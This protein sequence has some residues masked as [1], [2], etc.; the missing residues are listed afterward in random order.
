MVKE[1][2]VQ[3]PACRRRFSVIGKRKTSPC[4]TRVKELPLNGNPYLR[5]GRTITTVDDDVNNHQFLCRA[6]RDL[7]NDGGGLNK[8][9]NLHL[10]NMKI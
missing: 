5:V 8:L 4:W 6:G 3:K 10:S 2:I 9:T 1:I 7:S